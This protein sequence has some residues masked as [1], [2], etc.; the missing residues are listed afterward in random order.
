MGNRSPKGFSGSPFKTKV[1]EVSSS[2]H[3]S[4]ASFNDQSLST[5]T[6]DSPSQSPCLPNKIAGLLGLDLI[7]HMTDPTQDF[8]DPTGAVV[9]GPEDTSDPLGGPTT[10]TSPTRDDT[11]SKTGQSQSDTT[12]KTDQSQQDSSLSANINPDAHQEMS[13]MTPMNLL[14]S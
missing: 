13:Q 11:T 12:P 3:S 10:V 9:K 6:E 8:P 2:V 7:L 14:K 5:G 4:G 1:N